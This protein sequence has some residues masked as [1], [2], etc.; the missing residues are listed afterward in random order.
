MADDLE[1]TDDRGARDVAQL[2]R[3][4]RERRFFVSTI[5]ASITHGVAFLMFHEGDV[6]FIGI[7]VAIRGMNTFEGEL[8]RSGPHRFEITETLD[9]DTG[10]NLWILNSE[11][12]AF[13]IAAKEIWVRRGKSKGSDKGEQGQVQL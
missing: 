5:R 12:N 1:I 11:D 4:F 10:V 3:A 9:Q 13:R 8:V 7:A 2:I 6:P